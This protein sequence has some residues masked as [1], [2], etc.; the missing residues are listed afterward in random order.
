MLRYA[1]SYLYVI[2]NRASMSKLA[3][4][5][6]EANKKL[7][8]TGPNPPTKCKSLSNFELGKAIQYA[9]KDPISTV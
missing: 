1:C 4:P 9:E 8:I 2:I 6:W 5:V 7:A 3:L